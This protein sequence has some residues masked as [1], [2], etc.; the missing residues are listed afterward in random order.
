MG[1]AYGIRGGDILNIDEINN[2]I[3]TLERIHNCNIVANT[4][5]FNDYVGNNDFRSEFYFRGG[6]LS[7]IS[8]FIIPDSVTT[9]TAYPDIIS[10]KNLESNSNIT[11]TAIQSETTTQNFTFEGEDYKVCFLKRTYSLASSGYYARLNYEIIDGNK[12]LQNTNLSQFIVVQE[13]STALTLPRITE[14]E[15]GAY[16]DFIFSGVQ[17]YSSFSMCVLN[18]DN[19]VYLQDYYSDIYGA[20]KS[21]PFSSFFLCSNFSYDYVVNMKL[22]FKYYSSGTNTFS[23]VTRN[24]SFTGMYGSKEKYRKKI[25]L[26]ETSVSFSTTY[27]EYEV[28]NP[29]NFINALKNAVKNADSNDKIFIEIKNIDAGVTTIDYVRCVKINNQIFS[30]IPIAA[31]YPLS[32]ATLFSLKQNAR[33]P[34]SIELFEGNIGADLSPKIETNFDN[35]LI[36]SFIN[37][38]HYTDFIHQYDLSLYNDF[39]LKFGIG[40]Y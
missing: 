3:A 18:N 12:D 26:S 28:D 32:T 13:P 33:V 9:P 37:G 8:V 40:Q 39:V 16:T 15:T 25:S 20:G 24:Q 1:L 17:D 35:K 5:F 10:L 2:Y 36:T 27:K 23:I 4:I 31:T 38:L 34:H 21:L 30:Y 14:G 11:A 7:L 22:L 19:D 6:V 29:K